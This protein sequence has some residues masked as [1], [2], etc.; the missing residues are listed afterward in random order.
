MLG[1]RLKRFARRRVRTPLFPQMEA[2]E[3][4][5]ACLGSVLAHY[6]RW[7]SLETLRVACR[8][9]RDG[10]SAAD[11][12]VAA[13]KY[14]L[15]VTGWTKSLSELGE[16][17]LP[18]ILFWEFNHFVVLEG[19]GPDR[20][21]LNDPAIGRR[22]VDEDTFS[23]GFTGVLLVIQPG[24]EFQP[25]GDPPNVARQLWPWLRDVKGPL[26]FAALCGFLLAL[27]GLALPMLLSV[28]VDWVL[29]GPKA[30]WGIWI[31]AT[32]V[33]AGGLTYL[34]IYLQQRCL[35]RLA[36]FLSVVHAERM[37][38]RLFRLP[39]S[40]FAQRFAGD[41]LSRVQ[42]V[43]KVA[44]SAS[45]QFVGVVIELVMS[46][47]FL[48]AMLYFNP[49]LGLLVAGLGAANVILMRVVTNMRTDHN[50]QLKKEQAFLFGLGAFGLR[51]IHSLRATASEDDFFAR[52]AGTQAN[53][54]AARQRFMELGY[55]IAALPRVFLV[56]CNAAVL[57][58]G[59]WLVI[60]GD[61]TL[62]AMMGF[63]ML[64]INFLM[65]VGRF[66]Q[67]ADAFQVLEA[68]LKRIDD[69]MHAPES[70]LLAEREGESSGRVATLHGRPR[71]VGHIE[72]R[73][74]TFGYRPNH[75]PL[76]DGLSL[77]V[78]P[79]QRVAVIGGTGSGKSTLLKLV[80]GEYS[81]WSGQI[82]FDG[83]PHDQIPRQI[84]NESIA[85]VDQQILLFAAT[86]RDNLTS[87]NPGVPDPDLL[88]AAHDALIHNVIV[89]RPLGYDSKVEEGGSNFSG[90]ERQRLELGRALVNNP[91]VLF[92][93]EATS[94]LDAV[95]E[96]RIDDALRQRGC[97]CLIVAHRLSTIRDCDL[98]IVLDQGRE[99]QRGTHE[100]LL[101]DEDGQY[102]RLVQAQ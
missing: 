90:G 64:S 74:V 97:T 37:L 95:T 30:D 17:E 22:A 73:N 28:F 87:W 45:Q 7:E 76:I 3:C 54:L 44:V 93:D 69:I 36:V 25:G 42:I 96:M 80:S 98:I 27:P 33:A 34:L 88:Q 1:I 11:I 57:G 59:G 60:S 35:R 49:L 55:V 81:P 85:I 29:T 26:A 94:T 91:S 40:Y 82:L 12:A 6:G 23:G 102:Y 19:V 75:P 67:Y 39:A 51:N 5:A 50:V 18:A 52:L 8:V 2:S 48:A 71:L 66:V 9:S 58:L 99:V 100:E 13:K 83:V 24:P 16:V 68:D 84:L 65:P 41:L 32:T 63:Y 56:L 46:G 47:L 4:G 92:L 14:N 70:S 77:T 20:Y 78:A 89:S 38:S 72:L 101:A 15:Q 61:M 53:E 43:E 21:Y 62:G 86:V 10:S 79:G 31:V